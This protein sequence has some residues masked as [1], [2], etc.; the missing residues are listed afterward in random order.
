MRKF[1][2][3]APMDAVWIRRYLCDGGI[4]ACAAEGVWGLCCDPFNPHAVEAIT[5]LKGRAVG[6]GYILVSGQRRHFS[7]LEG[8]LDEKQVALLDKHWPGP[9]SFVFPDPECCF[10]PWVATAA[11]QE[12]QSVALRHTNHPQMAALSNLLASPLVSTSANQAGAQ[13]A[14]SEQAVVEFFG[15]ELV[16]VLS[17]PSQPGQAST[18]IDLKT[19]EKIR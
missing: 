13:P 10:P 14:I 17:A 8:L 2:L 6:K 16:I 7:N 3:A 5:R 4:V 11:Q 18:I 19:G 15:D 12:G 9:T 1:D